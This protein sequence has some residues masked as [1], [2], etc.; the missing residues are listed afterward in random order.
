MEKRC[1]A[2]G[3]IDTT[4]YE[5]RNSFLA[6][7]LSCRTGRASWV[8]VVDTDMVGVSHKPRESASNANRGFGETLM[9]CNSLPPEI[10]DLIVDNLCDDSTTLKSCCFVSKSW[11][12]RTRR[13][14]FTRIELTTT[15]SLERWMKAFPD[16]SNSPAHYARTLEI[17]GLEVFDRAGADARAWFHSFNKITRLFVNTVE[18]D[19][20]RGTTLIPL[21]ELS[22]SLKS[23]QISRRSIPSPKVL[24]LICSFPLL[25]D[26]QLHSL[27]T[28][29]DT[30]HWVVPSAS[31]KFAGYLHLTGKNHFIAR[32]LLDFPDGLHFSKVLVRCYIGDAE[33]ASGLVAKCSN[34]LETLFVEYYHYPSSVSISTSAGDQNLID[35]SGPRHV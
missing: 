13:H 11:V 17:R 22:P 23:L 8:V 31:P 7:Y 21:H 16:P 15:P 26:L 19:T 25:E 29:K 10:L 30:D 3:T 20:A 24:D 5:P 12:P 27:G 1:H 4:W 6:V 34:T 2:P 35:A 18:W 28:E 9:P 32:R 14:L 33:S